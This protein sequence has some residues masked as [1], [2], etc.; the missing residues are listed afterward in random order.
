[1]TTMGPPDILNSFREQQQRFQQQP[2]RVLPPD[3]DLEG[4]SLIDVE[5]VSYYLLGYS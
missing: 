3:I 5:E 4:G 2:L 1:M